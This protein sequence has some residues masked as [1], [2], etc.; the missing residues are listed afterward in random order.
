MYD[1]GSI[2]YSGNQSCQ[3]GVNSVPTLFVLDIVWLAAFSFMCAFLFSLL[4]HL[5]V[6][7]AG[8]A[9]GFM[10]EKQAPAQKPVPELEGSADEPEGKGSA[11]EAPKVDEAAALRQ[12]AHAAAAFPGGAVTT[13]TASRSCG[14]SRPPCAR[15]RSSWRRGSAMSSGSGGA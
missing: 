1:S 8:I 2:Q 6:A 5:P 9:G 10:V 12:L 13:A 7:M 11:D 3:F 14:R 4:L 15:T